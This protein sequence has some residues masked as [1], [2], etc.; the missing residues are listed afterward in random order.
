MEMCDV[1]TYLVEAPIPTARWREGGRTGTPLPVPP[2]IANG[3]FDAVG[4]R[5][6]EV[7][8]TPDKV[9]K[10]LKSKAQGTTHTTAPRLPRSPVPSRCASRHPPKAPTAAPWSPA[11]TAPGGVR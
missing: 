7:P 4:V 3:I 11:T 9:L 6:D 1:I 5:I 8:A 10:A 2:A